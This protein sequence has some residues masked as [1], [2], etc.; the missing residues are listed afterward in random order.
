GEHGL[1][2]RLRAALAPGVLADA[3]FVG[4]FDLAALDR[5]EHDFGGHQLHH[6]GRRPQ[7]VGVLLEQHAAAV[8]L[9]QDRRRRIAVKTALVLLGALY[10]VIGGIDDPAPADRQR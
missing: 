10:A 2:A 5:V 9:D 4:E 7:F 8:G 6:A 3:V 1:A